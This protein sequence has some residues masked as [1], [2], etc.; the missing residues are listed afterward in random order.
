M[1]GAGGTVVLLLG[2]LSSSNVVVRTN[3]LRIAL[4]QLEESSPQVTNGFCNYTPGLGLFDVVVATE[5]RL[6]YVYFVEATPTRRNRI[7]EAIACS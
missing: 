3:M 4:K 1:L 5:C 7:R 6:Q 2:R